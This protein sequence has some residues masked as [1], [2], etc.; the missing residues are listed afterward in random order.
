MAGHSIA[1]LFLGQ[2]LMKLSRKFHWVF[3]I[4]YVAP[5]YYI[6]VRVKSKQVSVQSFLMQCEHS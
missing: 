1:C 5:V 2:P 4:E 3:V 6:Y